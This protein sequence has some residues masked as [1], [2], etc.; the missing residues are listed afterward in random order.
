MLSWSADRTDEGHR[1]YPHILLLFDKAPASNGDITLAIHC[2]G[3]RLMRLISC[4]LEAL[5][6]AWSVAVH[7]LWKLQ[8]LAGRSWCVN[9]VF[10]PSLSLTE[11]LPRVEGLRSDLQSTVWEAMFEVTGGCKSV[12]EGWDNCPRITIR[13]SL[14]PDVIRSPY[15]KNVGLFVLQ[16]AGRVSVAVAPGISRNDTLLT[17]EAFKRTDFSTVEAERK[18]I[19]VANSSGLWSY[20]NHGWRAAYKPWVS[21]RQCRVS[22]Q[23]C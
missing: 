6:T 14:V 5:L 11:G 9:I 19:L 7:F 20:D 21:G 17:H 16:F 18:W 12:C 1:W 3:L 22:R 2:R 15:I 10:D 8:L 13:I 23:I 4:I